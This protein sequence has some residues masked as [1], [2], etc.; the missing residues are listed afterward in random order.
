MSLNKEIKNNGKQTNK[1]KNYLESNFVCRQIETECAQIMY[2]HTVH[3]IHSIKLYRQKIRIY[4]QT[5]ATIAIWFV[6]LSNQ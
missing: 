5:A 4:R 2:P 3:L 6:N 1:Q